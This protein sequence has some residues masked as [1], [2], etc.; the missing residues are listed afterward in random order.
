MPIILR[1]IRSRYAYR[2]ES[3]KKRS[4]S[5]VR[6]SDGNAPT[7]PMTG[8]RRALADVQTPR[9]NA[10]TVARTLAMVGSRTR[11][12]RTLVG[13]RLRHGVHVRG[14]GAHC[15]GGHRCGDSIRMD[16]LGVA[17]APRARVHARW[18]PMTSSR[19][20][21]I[22]LS[23]TLDRVFCRANNA[24][25]PFEDFVLPFREPGSGTGPILP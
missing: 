23:P 17:D 1:M 10:V 18:S 21:I 12:G 20:I 2:Y 3:T 15:R 14:P 9:V 25:G 16:L 19:L 13:R 8:R 6:S 5:S 24:P 4:W 22:A 7:P 11:C